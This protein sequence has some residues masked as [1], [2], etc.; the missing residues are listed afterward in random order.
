[1]NFQSNK[2]LSETTEIWSSLVSTVK[3]YL[4]LTEI[5]YLMH[6]ILSKRQMHFNIAACLWTDHFI[7]LKALDH[8]FLAKQKKTCRSDQV[9]GRHSEAAARVRD[10]QNLQPDLKAAGA[11]TALLGWRISRW[12]GWGL[13]ALSQA[14]LHPGRA[15]KG[16][17]WHRGTTG[18]SWFPRT[19]PLLFFF[20]W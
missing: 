19:Y 12:R 3:S 10:H 1:M 11:V 6:I 9:E 17:F 15:A 8:L 14:G 4:A 2:T 13:V 5:I 7:L 20:L 16:T 18:G